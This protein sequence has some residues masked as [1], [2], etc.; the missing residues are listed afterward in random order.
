ML[1]LLFWTEIKLILSTPG[2]S[3]CNYKSSRSSPLKISNFQIFWYTQ[4]EA[5]DDTCVHL[6]LEP[7]FSVK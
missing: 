3:E 4:T 7:S 1:M 6:V 2:F 5:G